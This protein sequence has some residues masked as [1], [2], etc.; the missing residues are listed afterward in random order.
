MTPVGTLKS[1]MIDSSILA[2][3]G[4][5]TW[6]IRA[7]SLIPRR[8]TNYNVPAKDNPPNALIHRLITRF[9]DIS[10]ASTLTRWDRCH[11]MHLRVNGWPQLSRTKSRCIVTSPGP[12]VHFFKSYA[13]RGVSYFVANPSS[14]SSPIAVTRSPSRSSP[15]SR[16][17]PTSPMTGSLRGQL[18][19]RAR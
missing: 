18:A 4:S 8:L 10:N 5:N 17:S 11:V 16:T 2:K 9:M 12:F 15:R 19:L 1:F 7:S 3:N 14:L 13:C 6:T